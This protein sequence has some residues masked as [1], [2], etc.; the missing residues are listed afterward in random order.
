MTADI[1][2]RIAALTQT[3]AAFK[4]ILSRKHD[5]LPYF[6]VARAAIVVDD[7]ANRLRDFVQLLQA[8]SNGKAGRRPRRS[9]ER[10]AR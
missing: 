8:A 9:E 1:L 2:D 10:V 3:L 4:T 6:L 7:A 5:E